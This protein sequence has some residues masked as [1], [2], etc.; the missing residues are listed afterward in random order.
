[1]RPLVL[2]ICVLLVFSAGLWAFVEQEPNNLYSDS[3]VLWCENGS[4]SGT[5]APM[6]DTD[7]WYFVGHDEDTVQFTLSTPIGHYVDV[8]IM[9]LNNN[10]VA[11]YFGSTGSISFSFAPTI[12]GEHYY[13][14]IQHSLPTEVTYTLTSSG[15]FYT[16]SPL[17][18]PPYDIS[19]PNGSTNVSV[20]TTGLSWTWGDGSGLGSWNFFFGTDP[21]NLDP[22]FDFISELVEVRAGQAPFP[23]ALAGGTTYYYQFWYSNFF[24]L[25]QLTPL[26]SFTTGPRIL[27]TPISENFDEGMGN[28]LFPEWF[29]DARIC[30]NGQSQRTDH[31]SRSREQLSHR[32]WLSRS[33]LCSTLAAQ[34]PPYLPDGR[35]LRSRLC[36][37]L[38][39]W[40]PHLGSDASLQLSGQRNL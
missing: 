35:K 1:M 37:L 39:R 22:Y 8:G 19:I 25:Q 14:V 16:L 30:G 26:Y 9:D 10:P 40:R 4:H 24:G 27:P 7:Y 3:N 36:G 20:E 31:H 13:V 38:H 23:A 15:Q 17:P 5:L 2:L 28:L 29:L 21:A 6:L 32:D 12:Q 18:S 34:F 33:E 11:H